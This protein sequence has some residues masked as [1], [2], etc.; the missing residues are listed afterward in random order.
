MSQPSLA[1]RETKRA[2]SDLGR[3]VP[4]TGPLSSL[5][6]LRRDRLDQFWTFITARQRIWEARFKRRQAPP[7][8]D[9]EILAR[10]RFTNVYRELDPGTQYAINEILEVDAPAPDRVFNIMIYR[11]IGKSETHQTLGFQHLKT[12]DHRRMEAKLKAIRADGVPPFTAAY[13]VSGYRSM[14]STDKVVNVS[15]LFGRLHSHFGEFFRRLESAKDLPTAY[16]CILSEDGFGNFLAYQTLV[17]L[18]YAT[19]QEKGRPLLPFSHNDWAAAGPG[20]RRGIDILRF[21]PS[22]S[23]LTVMRWLRDSQ[24]PEFERLSLDF[25]YL[26]DEMGKVVPISLA[27]VQNCLCEFHKYLKIKEGTGRGRRLFTPRPLEGAALTTLYA[28]CSG[29]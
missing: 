11:L 17:D 24:K 9:D 18:M 23:D 25:P 19:K 20:A 27:N 1:S 8:T 28:P 5:D 12:F 10:Q 14:G 16:S 2:E 4:E 22:V 21:N 29:V 6:W 13:M 26:R 3:T 15:R 7:W